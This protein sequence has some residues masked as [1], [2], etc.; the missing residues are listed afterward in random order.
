MPKYIVNVSYTSEGSKGLRKDGGTKRAG[1]VDRAVRGLGGKLEAF[2]FSLGKYD[3]VAIVDMPDTVSVAGL[4]LAVSAGGG[5]E[6]TTAEL[7]TPEDMDRACSKKTAY[8][9][10]GA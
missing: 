5:A 3:V 10:P 1:I 6:C 2:Y 8:R 7:L 9:A 4:S